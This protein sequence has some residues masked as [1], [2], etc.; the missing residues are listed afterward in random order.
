MQTFTDELLN[1]WI[2]FNGNRHKISHLIYDRSIDTPQKVLFLKYVYEQEIL[3]HKS[4]ILIIPLLQAGTHCWETDV[5]G[6]KLRN[7]SLIFK[8]PR[9]RIWSLW[10]ECC[11]EHVHHYILEKESYSIQAQKSHFQLCSCYRMILGAF[12]N[13][14]YSGSRWII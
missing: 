1:W 2:V 5:N 12:N 8:A 14:I 7:L 9:S 4:S 11:K 13:S 10:L 6:A 3:M